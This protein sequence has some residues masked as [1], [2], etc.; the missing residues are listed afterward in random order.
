[1]SK[2]T[3][4]EIFESYRGPVAHK[5]EHYIPIYERHFERHRHDPINVL[6]IGVSRG[7]SLKIWRE[8]F[9]S[10][11]R[12][13]GVDIN[14]SCKRLEAPE[15]NVFVR[16]GSQDDSEFLDNVIAEFG[17]ISLVIDDGSHQMHHVL[18]SF[19]YLFP[20][21]TPTATYWIEDMCCS[22]WPSFGG[23]LRREG[24]VIE[25]AK[26]CVDILNRQHWR[27]RQPGHSTEI[28]NNCESIHFYDSIIVLEKSV[29]G[30]WAARKFG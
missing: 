12:I 16:I 25:Y 20:R 18:A 29:K 22:Y 26:S 23:G 19:E 1:M 27:P 4:A 8:Y 14:P 2:P 10:Q 28:L 15:A 9:H 5:V 24:S 13:I 17:P 3:L 30:T 6:E 11:T 7:G 21:L